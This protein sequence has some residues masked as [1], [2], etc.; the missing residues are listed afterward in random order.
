[1][2][3]TRGSSPGGFSGTEAK[4]LAFEE[5]SKFC[6]AKGKKMQVV[7]TQQARMDPL[8]KTASA[9]V[10]FMCLIDGDME[11]SRPKLT[12]TPDTVIE[13]KG[14]LAPAPRVQ[15]DQPKDLYA[16][17]L[18]LEDLKGRGLLSDT[19]FEDQRRRLLSGR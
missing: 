17:M 10:Q 8:G 15:G 5:A 14:S 7:N 16:E 12:K 9:E 18:K 19:E 13:V 2:L 3:G 4:A 11:L 6:I 1:M